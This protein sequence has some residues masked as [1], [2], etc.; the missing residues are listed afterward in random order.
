MKSCEIRS[1][2]GHQRC[3]FGHK[4]QRLEHHMRSPI[5]IAHT[6]S[7][8][9]RTSALEALLDNAI[10]RQQSAQGVSLD[11]EAVDLT[12]FQQAYQASAQ[13][14]ATADS[15]YKTILNAVQRL[16]ALKTNCVLHRIKWPVISI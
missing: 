15:I 16:P 4:I 3:Q 10:D 5:P 13:I 9:N 12:R 11:E 7:A 8:K 2:L 6:N 1:R 14:I